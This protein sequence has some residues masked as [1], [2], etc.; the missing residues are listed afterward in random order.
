MRTNQNTQWIKR[1]ILGLALG[2]ACTTNAA[3]ASSSWGEELEDDN[4]VY[5]PRFDF[6]IPF[7]VDVTGQAP[8]EIQLEFSDDLG[9]NWAVYSK[10][11]VRTKQFQFQ[12]PSDGEYLFRLKTLDSRGRV[13]DNPGEPLRVVVDTTKPNADLLIDI[14]QRGLMLA[15]FTISDPAIDPNSIQL[16]YHTESITQSREIKFDL[17]QGNNAGELIGSGSW[18]IP[19]GT[20]LLSVRLTGKDKAGNVVEVTRLPQLPRSAALNNGLQ[21]ASGKTREGSTPRITNVKGAIGSGVVPSAQDQLPKVQVLGG[22]RSNT[23]ID[24]KIASQLE[25]NQEL[26]EQ[27]KQLINNLQSANNLLANEGRSRVDI[28]SPGTPAAELQAGN[29]NALGTTGRNQD[30]RKGKS[31]IRSMTDEEIEQSTA[32]MAVSLASKRGEQS[33]LTVTPD[34]EPSQGSPTSDVEL[35]PMRVPVQPTFHRNIKPLHSSSKMFSLDY[36]IENDTDSPVASVEL[37]GTT[38]EG[39]TWQMWGQDPDRSSPFDIQVESEGL[40]GFRMIIVGT[41][42]LASNRPRNGDNADAWILVDTQQPK[43]RLIS[44]LYGKGSEAGSMIIEYKATDDFL[45]ER[46][47]NL[48]Y[49]ETPDG[50]WVSIATGVRNSGRYVWAADPSLPQSIYLK[51]EAHDA[52]GNIGANQLD[53][54]VDVQGLAPRGRIQGFRPLK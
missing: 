2:C 31:P 48:S 18:S 9:V 29:F 4:R 27:Q 32:P 52:A 40:F 26:I 30:V 47:I 51:V 7:N 42:G 45:P 22:S 33:L 21:L 54:P 28:P 12:A 16:S 11:D 39:Q 3:L 44:A 46:P 34:Q 19:E 20:R 35:K 49:S 23:V 43:V 25:Q 5:W 50:P 37:W 17:S 1:S 14:D 10:S 13:F 15:E 24:Q 38:D 6:V 8:R 36:N 41:N 53:V